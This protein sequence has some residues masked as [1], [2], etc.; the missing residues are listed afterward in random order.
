MLAPALNQIRQIDY[1]NVL[2]ERGVPRDEAVLEANKTRLRPILMTTVMLIAGMV[3]I[4]IG[5]GPGTA[6][7]ASIAKVIIGGQSLSLLLSLLVTP[8]AYLY[9]DD[10]GRLWRRL[11]GGAEPETKPGGAPEPEVPAA[12]T[13]D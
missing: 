7:R 13:P 2:R 8:V 1:T 6:S 9:F 10:A 5:V 4:A 12:A 3:P 11:R